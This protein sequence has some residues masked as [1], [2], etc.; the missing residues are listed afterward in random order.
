MYAIL[1][2]GIFKKCIVFA[3]RDLNIS[4]IIDNLENI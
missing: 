1:A 4:A 3:N 2:L